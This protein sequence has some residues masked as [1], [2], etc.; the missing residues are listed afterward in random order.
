[1]DKYKTGET[2]EIEVGKGSF[3]DPFLAANTEEELPFNIN[4]HSVY[5]TLDDEKIYM[6]TGED[7]L[8]VEVGKIPMSS[9]SRPPVIVLHKSQ[10]DIGKGYLLDIKN[11]YCM[12]L[13]MAE[14]YNIIGF[15]S[16]NEFQKYKLDNEQ[17][18][19]KLKK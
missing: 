7:F 16:D 14:F 17:I 11:P 1:M 9:R 18:T 2:I 4:T 13:K 8:K 12:N 5:V 19:F 10:F 3:I 15:L 6:I